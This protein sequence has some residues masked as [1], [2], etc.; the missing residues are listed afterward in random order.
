MVYKNS[1]VTLID[2]LMKLT[3]IYKKRKLTKS[4]LSDMIEFVN[5]LLPKPNIFPDSKYKFFKIVDKLSPQSVPP[6]VEYYCATC[7]FKY[8]EK[9]LKECSRCKYKITAVC[10]QNNV[11]SILKHMFEYRGLSKLVED[12]NEVIQNR[13]PGF[14]RDLADGQISKNITEKS[15]YTLNLIQNTDGFP[16]AN[17]SNKQIWPNFLGISSIAPALRPKFIICAGLW[18]SPLKANLLKFLLPFAQEMK[19]LGSEGFKWQHP[20]T[21]TQIVSTVN[22]IASSL[23]ASA[24]APALL[25]NYFN[26]EYGCAFCEIKGESVPI[27]RKPGKEITRGKKTVHVYPFP[28]EPQTLRTRERV[29]QQAEY[30]CGVKSRQEREQRN[31]PHP[32]DSKGIRG[33]SPFS[34]LPNF[35]LVDS[36][37]PD[38]L[39]ST[40]IGVTKR[41]TKQILN[42]KNH[43]E[44]FYCGKLT[45]IINKRI[46]SLQVPSF[47]NRLPRNLSMLAFWKASEFRNWLFFYSLPCLHKIL[48][49]KYFLHHC[50]YVEAIF[51]LCKSEISESDLERAKDLIE[52]YC[53]EYASLYGETEMTFNL[54]MQTHF[55]R[56][57]LMNGPL[58]SHSTFMFEG[59]N[60]LLRCSIHGTT[61]IAQELINTNKV[62]NALHTMQHISEIGERRNC[63]GKI[64]LLGAYFSLSKITDSNIIKIIQNKA[65]TS[66]VKLY[67]RCK[68]NRIVYTTENY[69][70][71]S[72]TCSHY[73]ALKEPAGV[74]MQ[75]C[76]LIL[77]FMTENTVYFLGNKIEILGSP[78]KTKYGDDVRHI[79]SFK[80]TNNILCA[81]AKHIIYPLYRI[82]EYLAEP[83]NLYEINL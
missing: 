3:F 61:N 83:P 78:F 47:V 23:D 39:H 20:T 35:N 5:Y 9:D 28:K 34:L 55:H 27:K 46:D 51:T 12:Y 63:P 70:R 24:R 7:L 50:L 1:D 68:I 64:Q 33:F 2:A 82:L 59:N 38:Y 75:Y 16:F 60:G 74:N 18:F 26:S 15:A 42:T 62:Y 65:G 14:I 81:E 31:E 29:L 40:L 19:R 45:N 10:V 21:K 58:W 48:K 44:E 22:V 11:E 32:R 54:H 76:K 43:S 37:S 56:A 36:N 25:M 69:L 8:G 13:S 57:C 67:N 17:S 73:V 66:A 79:K 77:F 71:E 49:E 30:V 41:W 72:K 6:K 53:S 80:L 52:K 4:T